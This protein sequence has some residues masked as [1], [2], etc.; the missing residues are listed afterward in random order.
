MA[1]TVLSF[2]E[3]LWDLLPTGPMLGG[4]PCNFA[5]RINSLGDIGLIV[6]RLGRDLLGN[7]A[8]SQVENLG[9]DTRFVQRDPSRATGTVD[10]T[11]DANQQPDYVIEPN[12]AYDYIEVT[13]PLLVAT[14]TADCLCFG[15]LAQREGKS[16]SALAT[17]LERGE[18]CLKLLDLNL[19]KDCYSPNLIRSSLGIAD[20][21]KLNDDELEELVTT[22]QL[23]GNSIP[24]WADALVEQWRLQFCLVTMGERGAYAADDQG[25]QVYVPGFKV[26][27]ANPCGSGDAFTAGFVHLFL[28]G[29][30]IEAC[31]TLG[32]AL[33]AMVAEQTGCTVPI[34]NAEIDMFLALDHDRVRDRA[35]EKYTIDCEGAVLWTT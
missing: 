27:L 15:T 16:R 3:M 8:V 28:R 32:N 4:A 9:M 13:E 1:K 18:G 11:F 5:F 34:T 14:E 31:C 10:I 35:L 26:N 7:K 12:V 19:R 23:P 20:A 22:V 29:Q 6:T 25:K 30:A 21:L 17:I 33:G 24:E 2:G